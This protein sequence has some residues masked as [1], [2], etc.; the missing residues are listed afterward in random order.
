M[1]NVITLITYMIIINKYYNDVYSL[2]KPII[3][4]T[5]WLLKSNSYK[6]DENWII[7]D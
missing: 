4:I 6:S 2:S 7:I 3:K 5:K 1:I